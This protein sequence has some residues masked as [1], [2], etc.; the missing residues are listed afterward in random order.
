MFW[1]FAST[2]TFF[3][4]SLFVQLL[5]D[6]FVKVPVYTLYYS[7]TDTSLSTSIFPWYRQRSRKK[8]WFVLKGHFLW[9]NKCSWYP[10]LRNSTVN[11]IYC[12]CVVFSKYLFVLNIIY[13]QLSLSTF[14]FIC[15]E[16]ENN[17]NRKM[18]T[19]V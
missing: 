3:N 9:T 10:A 13:L 5:L 8:R 16:I 4:P 14:V 11:A 6:I 1:V 2:R 15:W 18:K 12:V 7:S 17:K 19:F